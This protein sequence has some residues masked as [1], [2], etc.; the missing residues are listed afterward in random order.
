MT[1]RIPYLVLNAI[2]SIQ[3]LDLIDFVKNFDDDER[4]FMW[5]NDPRVKKIGDKLIND[6]HSGA[7]FAFTLRECQKIF[8]KQE[9]PETEVP[10]D[11]SHKN[12]ELVEDEA[13]KN[14]LFYNEI[15]EYNKKALNIMITKESSEAID[16]MFN[17]DTPET[18]S[19]NYAEM[20]VKYR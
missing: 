15:D 3:S 19:F 13:G 9:C 2:E 1:D 8:R 16:Y 7:S 10:E 14:Y 17:E 5:S 20:L 18:T 11:K 12:K 4:G 6:G